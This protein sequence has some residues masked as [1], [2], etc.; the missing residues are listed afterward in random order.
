[1][2]MAM[3]AADIISKLFPDKAADENSRHQF[4]TLYRQAWNKNFATRLRVGRL[5]QKLFGSPQITWLIIALLKPFP[6]LLRKIISLTHG[7]SF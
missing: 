3:R 5:F 1:M 2:S 7:R 4:E 6:S